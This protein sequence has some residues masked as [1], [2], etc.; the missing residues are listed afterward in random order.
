MARCNKGASRIL[1]ELQRHERGTGL[2]LAGDQ[3]VVVAVSV[4]HPVHTIR[5]KKEATREA[6]VEPL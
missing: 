6:V 5:G 4:G 1:L 3:P 2:P